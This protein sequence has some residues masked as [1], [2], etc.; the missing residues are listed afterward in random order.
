MAIAYKPF[1][2][3]NVNTSKEKNFYTQGQRFAARILFILWLLASISPDSTLA[4]P[5]HQPATTSPGY[6]SLASAFPTPLP[7]ARCPQ[8][9][10]SSFWGS[11]VASSLSID[12]AL[13]RQRP[14]SLRART[15]GKLAG[16]FW[17]P[18][19]QE[20]L[21]TL[22]GPVAEGVTE[23]SSPATP[24][25]TARQALK[26][27]YQE[28]FSEVP[29][30]FPEDPR[31]PMDKIQCHLMLLEQV[32]VEEALP[33]GKENQLL[34]IHERIEWQKRPIA[35]QDLFKKRSIKPD[36]PIEDIS[37]VLLIGEVGTGKTTLSHKIAHD[38]ARGAWGQDFTS[39]YLLPIRNLQRN[40][41]N[42][43]TPQTAPTLDTAIV[44]ECFPA[45]F[46][47]DEED[48]RRLRDQV[49]EEL[50]QP[51]T[52]VIL[53]GL[54]ERAG[55]QEEILS[56]A[57]RGV[58]KLLL[59]SRPYGIDTERQMIEL[60][61]EHLGF[62][63]AQID[64]YVQRYFQKRGK[65][66]RSAELLRFIK[67]HPAPAAVAHVPANLEWLCALWYRDPEGVCEATM[68]GSLSGFYCKLTEY[69][70]DRYKVHPSTGGATQKEL[71][72]QLGA[73]ALD[74]LA[75]STVQLSCEQVRDILAGNAISEAMLR[76]SGF[77][78][79][80]GVGQ[81]QFPHLT[82]QEY[83]AGCILAGKFLSRYEDEREEASEFLS[84]HKYA[85]Q[86]GRTLSFIAGEVSREKGVKGTKWLLSL[87]GEGDQERVRLQH[88]LLQLRVI[89]E[90]LCIASDQ[91]AER[92]MAELEREFGVLASLE[93][94]FGKGLEQVRIAGYDPASPGGRLLGLLTD[95]LQ[96]FRSVLRQAPGLL[97]LLQKAAK[98]RDW[99]VR[100]VAV[101]YLGQAISAV[102]HKSG[103]IL[104]TL[105]EAAKDDEDIYVRRAAVEPLGVAISAVPHE[106]DTI[107]EILREAAKDDA[108]LPIVCQ[109]AVA[110]LGVAISAVPHESGA[111]LATLREAAK[112]GNWK[113]R[114]A[115]VAALGQA[116]SAVPHESGAILAILRE[117]AKN[118]YWP[119]RQAAVE[120]LG[121]AIAAVPHESDTIL[122]ILREAAKDKK[123]GGYSVR[124]AAVEALGQAISAVPHESG[125]ILATLR[126]AAKDESKDWRGHYPVR[127]AANKFLDSSMDGLAASASN[128]PALQG[129][130]QRFTGLLKSEANQIEQT[131]HTY[132]LDK[133]VWE[134][135]YGAVGEE[136]TLPADI[137][138]MMNS[139][140]PFWPGNKLK[141][142]HLLVLIPSHVAGKPLTLDYLSELIKQPQG[143][144]YGT[145]YVGY[146]DEAREAIGSQSPDSSYWVLMTRGVLP[147]SRDKIYQDQRALVA[148]HA[149]HTGLAYEVPGAL[150]AAVVVLLHHVRSG[151]RLYLYSDPGCTYTRCRENVVEDFQ[152]VVGG[153]SSEGLD[154]DAHTSYDTDIHGIA[155][156]R[157]F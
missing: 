102:P 154:V 46:W 24:A 56:E 9:A 151:E 156:L 153:F 22:A 42:G 25:D 36:G 78:Q 97:D 118:D 132:K 124:A 95:P 1:R 8:A 54:D 30:F 64:A 122:E 150:E 67:A 149:S 39:V 16:R 139:A 107:L 142:T 45:N 141:D 10:P 58:H 72:K 105:R 127:E 34:A 61:I 123:V 145:K 146:W 85:P 77:L 129:N 38:W 50:K 87:L 90:W 81:Y 98:D 69:M 18:R 44:Q 120:V 73:I 63:D 103:A 144:G 75:Q 117:A 33:E 23:G 53:D 125:A 100:K 20:A 147:G 7:G 43:A 115:A 155:G 143:E 135:Y 96:V 113:V 55:A 114:Q 70:W 140:C 79:A 86:Y 88:L 84:E 40:Q 110:A 4:T 93:E 138:A 52:L 134:R 27:H 76:A 82:F 108:P 59:L 21:R 29:S 60:E 71:F 109:A 137:E 131:L 119:V 101:E 31:T 6:P 11:G 17:G 74:S 2:A 68:Q 92:G 152:M 13:Q 99:E 133:T 121:G 148:D 12:A 66:T 126:E 57:G 3:M 104:A 41:Y 94:W 80:A 19:P 15:I 83:F 28:H 49:Q 91:E 128:R 26:A 106:S 89:H 32:K 51:T 136:P 35:L 14:S 116:I 111:I 5:K 62:N 37:K 112:D 47:K 48:F 65:P 130:P 157:K